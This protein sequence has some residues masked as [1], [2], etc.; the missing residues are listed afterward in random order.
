MSGYLLGFALMLTLNNLTPTAPDLLGALAVSGALSFLMRREERH[1]RELGWHRH[2][3][4]AL[5]SGS[6]DPP[7]S[8][9]CSPRLSVE[10]SA[11]SP[12][13]ASRCTAAESWRRQE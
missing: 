4:G 11:R 8:E 13:I 2:T 12:R 9:T 1:A 10:P 6:D 3:V 5:H 7:T